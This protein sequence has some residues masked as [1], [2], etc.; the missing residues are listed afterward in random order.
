MNCAIEFP[1]PA[2]PQ[3]ALAAGVKAEMR[4]RLTSMCAALSGDPLLLADALFLLI[5][6]AYAV[7]HTIGGPAGPA[8][9]LPRAAR[10]LIAAEQPPAGRA[11]QPAS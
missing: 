6:G 8:A 10:A 11:G 3:H 1:D 7:C 5:E 2:T 4:H 9:A